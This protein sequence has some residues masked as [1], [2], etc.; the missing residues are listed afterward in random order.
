MSIKYENIFYFKFVFI[1][2]TSCLLIVF[3]LSNKYILLF[4]LEI[5]V[6]SVTRSYDLQR[7]IVLWEKSCAIRPLR[8]DRWLMCFF[9]FTTNKLQ[10]YFRPNNVKLRFNLTAAFMVG[11]WCVYRIY[12]AYT[13]GRPDVDKWNAFHKNHRRRTVSTGM[14][15]NNFFFF[16]Y[17]FWK[18]L[19][20]SNTFSKLSELHLK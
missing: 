8:I 11:T 20:N 3:F 6:T 18:I 9:F 19:L 14:R 4:S 13:R 10:F 15:Y 12:F 2:P 17:N 7:H 5:S 16:N 1:Y